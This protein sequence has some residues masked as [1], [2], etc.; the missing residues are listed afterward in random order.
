[1][2]RDGTRLTYRR[3]R[4]DIQAI[5]E[6]WLDEVYSPPREAQGLPNVVDLGANIGFTSVYL[7][8]RLRPAC[9]VAVEPDPENARILRR[10]LEQNDIHSIVIEAAVG[11]YDG[12]TGFLARSCIQPRAYFARR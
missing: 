11:P 10:N 12:T 3:N 6:I 4:G 7:A 2:L 8:R 9:I 1:M 5:R